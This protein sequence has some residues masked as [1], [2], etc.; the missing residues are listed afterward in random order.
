MFQI[1]EAEQRQ[2]ESEWN[3]YREEERWYRYIEG[4]K[5]QEQEHRQWYIQE[6]QRCERMGLAPPPPPPRPRPPPPPPA[7]DNS[8]KILGNQDANLIHSKH[9][10]LQ[11]NKTEIAELEKLMAIVEDTIEI[12]SEELDDEYMQS[13]EYKAWK[14]KVTAESQNTN[15]ADNESQSIKTEKK[16]E[17]SEEKTTVENTT[18]EKTTEEKTTETEEK[19]EKMVTADNSPA[20]AK[21]KTD[22]LAISALAEDD[23]LV[24]KSS[25]R[26]ADL[27]KHSVMKGKIEGILAVFCV[28][29]PTV[30]FFDKFL[31]KLKIKFAETEKGLDL[32]LASDVS[33]ASIFIKRVEPVATEVKVTLTSTVF[34]EEETTETSLTKDATEKVLDRKVCL[35]TLALLRQT[36]WFESRMSVSLIVVLQLLKD[37]NKRIPA[38]SPLTTWSLELIVERCARTKG[39]STQPPQFSPSEVLR[40]VFEFFA[41]GFLLLHSPGLND[42]CEKEPVDVLGYLSAQEREDLTASAQYALRLMVYNQLYKILGI[43]QPAPVKVSGQVPRNMAPGSFKRKA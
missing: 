33:Q 8:R 28:K 31:M 17:K 13:T 38:W 7:R 26:I 27:P 1:W 35:N 5:Q 32:V 18:E 30:A 12:V 39:Y 14:A 11:P 3:Q 2:L 9:N 15:A 10:Q 16:I 21:D 4:I 42:P 41:S 37:L 36:K 34:R 24:I 25:I 19:S 43:A 20:E 22:S 23:H 29:K 6:K 40:R